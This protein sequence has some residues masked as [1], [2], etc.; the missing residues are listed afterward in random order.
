MTVTRK[1]EEDEVI[2]PDSDGKP[3]ADNTLQFSY[4]ASL[5]YGFD[6]LF[7]EREDVFVA[8]DL[9]WYPVKGDNTIR[10]APD[11][12]IA[13]DRPKGYRGSYRQ[14][15]E[16]DQPPNV[17]YEVLSP[18][19]T[20]PEMK[21][22]RQAYD[23]YGVDEYYEYDPDRGLLKGWLRNPA[24]GK[25]KEISNMDRWQSPLTEVTMH[26]EGT[27]LVVTRPDGRIFLDSEEIEKEM[28]KLAA[29]VDEVTT[30][31]EKEA[32]RAEKEA[33]RAKKE[34][35]KAKKEAE[36]ANQADLEKQKLIEQLKAAGIEP[37]L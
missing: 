9:L 34:A 13:F 1:P 18:C 23:K 12:L 28:Q 20:R 33:A 19:N 22:K 17:V 15:E 26:L 2:Y 36:R 21:K 24:S 37:D 11:V 14:W 6:A 27:D 32:E 31:A 4:I 7:L 10:Y 30:R 8:G 3:M 16:N 25:L 5:K 35:E 29:Q